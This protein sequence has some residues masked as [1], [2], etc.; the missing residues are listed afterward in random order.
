[1]N[2]K[3]NQCFVLKM[4]LPHQEI[5]RRFG[6]PIRQHRHRLILHRPNTPNRGRNDD[7]LRLCSSGAQKRP[8]CLEQDKVRKGIDVKLVLQILSWRLQCN[9]NVL[10]DSAV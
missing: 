9:A 7:E 2:R 8:Y 6:T 1:M 4:Q 3:A 10:C 5:R